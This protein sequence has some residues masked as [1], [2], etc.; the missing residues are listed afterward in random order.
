MSCLTVKIKRI[1]LGIMIVIFI[2]TS[3]SFPLYTRAQ[4]V[5]ADPTHIGATVAGWAA[6]AARWAVDN[7][8]WLADNAMKIAMARVLR[9]MTQAIVTWIDSG[10][11]G[12]P[13][14]ITDTKQFIR[15]TADITIGDMLMGTDLDFLCDPFKIQVKLS[16][17]L[18]Y[19]PFRDE[20]KCSFTS[21][22]GNVN[23]AMT[24]FTNG[25]FIGG[26]GWDSWLQ[27][28]TVPQ[29]NQMGA[30]IIAQ[31]EL[32]AR[33]S[34]NKE[35]QL[36]E[37]NWGG[38]FMSWKKC[39]TTSV[40]TGVTTGD[41][42]Y[43]E[44][45]VGVSTTTDA[46]TG[47]VVSVGSGGGR[48]EY[49]NAQGDVA[50]TIQENQECTIQTPG[51]VISNKIN[52]ADS[53]DIRKTELA[54]DVNAIVNALINQLITE[55]SD[56]LLKRG[57]AN[58]KS[59]Q[60]YQDN[61]QYLASLQAQLAAQIAANGGGSGGGGSINNPPSP[62]PVTPPVNVTDITTA[63]NAI[64]AQKVIEQTYQ[65]AVNNVLQLLYYGSAT[66][67]AYGAFYE[68][69]TCN[70]LIQTN[71]LD[72]IDGTKPY[73]TNDPDRLYNENLNRVALEQM[74]TNSMTNMNSLNTLMTTV[75]AS[76]GDSATMAT[77]N[78]ALTASNMHT[79]NDIAS[80][81]I[82]GSQYLQIYAWLTI[83][84]TTYKGT[85]DACKADLSVWGI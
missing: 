50:G 7:G 59:S 40:S 24:D 37:A 74:R 51:S 13:A 78:Q 68:K 3:T 26:G 56:G 41:G 64:N 72:R 83:M 63:L 45:G 57:S 44:N 71:V 67:S 49:Y 47:Q 1:L 28:T 14:F 62:N 54:N 9:Q 8:R 12:S 34:G 82:G 21:A 77:V 81:T 42:V 15:D 11:N 53:S 2:F 33:I 70:S 4:F 73:S 31:G 36:T 23:K 29:N 43:D 39:K 60:A 85:N 19:R 22:L 80:L 5:V 66:S 27:M 65:Q 38:G 76:T 75:N 25:D 32:D 10:F 58:S 52:W 16:L 17:G 6:E 69:R 55:L 48:M 35:I 61:Q 84:Q 30:M 79:Q 18:Q 46:I 20:I